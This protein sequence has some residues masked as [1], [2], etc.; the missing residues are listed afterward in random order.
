MP[1]FTSIAF[2]DTFEAVASLPARMGLFRA[3]VEDDTRFI[4][5]RGH[6]KGASGDRIAWYQTYAKWPE[7][8]N[9]LGRLK[10]IGDGIVADPG[11][12]FGYIF[13][14][15]LDAGSV[16]A[17]RPPEDPPSW[18][19]VHL[20]LRTNPDA[21]LFAGR[22]SAHLLPGSLALVNRAIWSCAANWG[23]ASRIHLV[24]DFRKK[25]ATESIV[26]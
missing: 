7:M 1:V 18:L 5:L 20:P 19:R 22:E 8:K 11:I 15:M 12:E 6:P 10:R 9:I 17:W 4:P 16:T 13:L 2:L 24:A 25:A 26:T 21:F 14:E 3:A 23:E